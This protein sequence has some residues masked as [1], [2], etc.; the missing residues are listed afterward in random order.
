MLGCLLGVGVHL[1]SYSSPNPAGRSSSAPT[2]PQC[3]GSDA[4]RAR[5]ASRQ[6]L[7]TGLVLSR[8]PSS[9]ASRASGLSPSTSRCLSARHL[10]R[11]WAQAGCSAGR[12]KC[13]VSGQI[14]DELIDQ[15]P[16]Q[17][18][19]SSGHPCILAVRPEVLASLFLPATGC[20]GGWGEWVA[21]L[22]SVMDSNATRLDLELREPVPF[23]GVPGLTSLDVHQSI[24]RLRSHRLIDGT[25]SAAFQN[26]TWIRLRVTAPGLIVLGEW[27][28]L[29][30]VATAASLHRL[31][32]ALSED[33][34]EGDQTALKR[35]AGVI[36]RTTD[37]VLRGTVADVARSVG[38]E[39]AG[40]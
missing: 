19:L 18:A 35:A 16:R 12:L 39:A 7:T 40:R 26:S 23:E 11:S 20:T 1:S 24:L 4:S 27:P 13:P 22:G 36:S 29:D 5:A 8:R 10:L 37:E 14:G 17:Q 9:S 3:R 21:S 31:L 28:D 15:I 34:P 30:R 2:G 6:S 33:A 25:E 32:R 38:E